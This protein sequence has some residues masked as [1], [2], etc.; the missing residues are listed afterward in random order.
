MLQESYGTHTPLWVFTVITFFIWLLIYR[1]VPETEGKTL[2][3]IQME[4]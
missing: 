2:E 1:Y 4:L 3:E